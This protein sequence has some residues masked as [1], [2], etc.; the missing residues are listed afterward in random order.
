M[1]TSASSSPSSSTYLPRFNY[2]LPEAAGAQAARPSSE[3]VQNK[4]R[5]HTMNQA[6]SVVAAELQKDPQLAESMLMLSATTESA[7]PFKKVSL[8]Q[9]CRGGDCVA[10]VALRRHRAAH[11]GSSDA[12]VCCLLVWR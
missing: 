3:V 8:L 12:R 1:E 6:V 5:Q 2:P 9:A 7:T 4:K 11:D 10:V